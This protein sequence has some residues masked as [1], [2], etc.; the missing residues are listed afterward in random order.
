M[1]KKPR[2]LTSELITVSTIQNKQIYAWAHTDITGSHTKR[3]LSP[4]PEMC[5]AKMPC[6]SPGLGNSEET[7][8]NERDPM[9]KVASTV[10]VGEVLEQLVQ[11]IKEM[12]AQLQCVSADIA[13][14]SEVLGQIH[15]DR[16]CRMC[17]VN[18]E[19]GRGG[20]EA[21]KS[22]MEVSQS[23]SARPLYYF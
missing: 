14:Q 5:P 13:L 2:N 11:E 20:A 22:D 10:E 4:S 18:V 15:T 21:N 19:C 3:C 8:Q 7:M 23:P 16:S 9:L 17:W 6:K 1:D 12:R